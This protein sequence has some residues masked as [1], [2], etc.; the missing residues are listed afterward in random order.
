M[1]TLYFEI[2]LPF[3]F[4]MLNTG[5]NDFKSSL[6]EGFLRVKFTCRGRPMNIDK[7]FSSKDMYF[8]IQQRLH[9]IVPEILSS[10]CIQC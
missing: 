6:N 4:F 5:Q 10:A 9:E 3:L 1:D 8:W 7:N 2:L